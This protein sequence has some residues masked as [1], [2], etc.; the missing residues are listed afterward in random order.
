MRSTSKK[1]MQVASALV[2][3]AFGGWLA[4]PAAHAGFNIAV[5]G[6][7]VDT[8]NSADQ[9]YVATAV[10][11]GTGGAFTE[12]TGNSGSFL[13]GLQVVVSTSAAPAID[14][15]GSSS[16]YTA[17][18]D[19]SVSV[20]GGP[21]TGNQPIFGDGTG[22]TFIGVGNEN[23]A[24]GSD[25]APDEAFNEAT[26][27]SATNNWVTSLGTTGVYL[28]SNVNGATPNNA[29]GKASTLDPAFQNPL[30]LGVST[31]NTISA[32]EVDEVATPGTGSGEGN[33]LDTQAV[34]FANIVVANGTTGSVSG[35]LGGDL[36]K[37]VIFSVNFGAASTVTA[38][39]T[40]SVT[41]SAPS[42]GTLIGTIAMS[43]HNGS[44]VPMSIAVTG[45]AQTDGYLQVGGFTAGDEEIYALTV[46][47]ATSATIGDLNAA[48]SAADPGAQ[49]IA[50][51][52]TI[53]NLFPGATIELDVPGTG[54]ANPDFLAYDLAGSGETGLAITN[55]GVVP[56]PTGIGFL[57]LGGLG[58]VARRRRA[59]QA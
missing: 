13:D 31:N 7:F 48:L 59:I 22:G 56:E 6:P 24:A 1:K 14:L 40:L 35:V 33:V 38:V 52:P 49:A 41:N 36:G 27:A 51:T 43:G 55:I 28:N 26:T 9:I 44:Y 23:T 11:E 25:Q 3:A 54:L 2:A 45:A 21:D 46:T 10:N 5:V 42:T 8:E 29:S 50:I 30:T 12:S 34:P 15:T 39:T 53:A 47:G 57:I 32:L 16:K 37:P 17:N 20:S 19:G 18:V 4:V 58:L